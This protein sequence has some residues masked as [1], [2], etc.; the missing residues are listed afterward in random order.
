MKPLKGEIAM[1]LQNSSRDNC[2]NWRGAVLRTGD[3]VLYKA[4]HHQKAQV[5]QIV[6][7]AEQGRIPKGELSGVETKGRTMRT[8]M[9]LV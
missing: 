8:R 3:N 2:I 5:E 7:I 9:T 6:D 4:K 1:R